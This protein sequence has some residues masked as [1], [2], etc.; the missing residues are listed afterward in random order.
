MI[1]AEFYLIRYFSKK[2]FRNSS[3]LCIVFFVYKVVLP[4]RAISY[5]CSQDGTDAVKA[6]C[7][8]GAFFS[9]FVLSATLVNS[10]FS[11]SSSFFHLLVFSDSLIS[12]ASC[13][14]HKDAQR[15]DAQRLRC[16]WCF[17]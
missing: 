12:P 6:T 15:K 1:A 4:C 10:L 14:V 17:S 7:P 9:F 2:L 5:R 13:G 8:L 16:T 3:E 11:K